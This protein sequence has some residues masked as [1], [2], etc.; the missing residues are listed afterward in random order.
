[1][2]YENAAHHD[3]DDIGFYSAD[4]SYC[5]DNVYNSDDGDNDDTND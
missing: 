2:I 3:D 1:V 5:D 4:C